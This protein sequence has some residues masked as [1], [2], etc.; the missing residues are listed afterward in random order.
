MRSKKELQMV[1]LRKVLNTKIIKMICSKSLNYMDFFLLT[2]IS[3]GK[4]N[5]NMAKIS[6]SKHP[7]DD[8]TN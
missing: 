7:F 1:N 3:L 4:Y 2:A 5:H 8:I 6:L